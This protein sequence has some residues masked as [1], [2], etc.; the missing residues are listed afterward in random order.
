MNS[1]FQV[2]TLS[3]DEITNCRGGMGWY[4]GY[5]SEDHMRANSWL[6][7]GTAGFL[8]GLVEGLYESALEATR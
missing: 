2:S 6:I 3:F 4:P 8:C 7:E 1:N 5:N